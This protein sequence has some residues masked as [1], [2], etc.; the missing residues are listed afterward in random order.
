MARHAS[1]AAR[2]SSPA[3]AAPSAIATGVAVVLLALLLLALLPALAPPPNAS[4]AVRG[5]GGG[6]PPHDASQLAASCDCATCQAL[7]ARYRIPA[8]AACAPSTCTLCHSLLQHEV[9][10]LAQGAP[11]AAEPLPLPQ[12]PA[13]PLPPPP[14]QQQQQQ[15]QPPAPL[16]SHLPASAFPP[17]D[18]LHLQPHA[19]RFLGPEAIFDKGPLRSASTPRITLENGE[20]V[21]MHPLGYVDSDT[22]RAIEWRV[23]EGAIISYVWDNEKS[24]FE[25]VAKATRACASAPAGSA[26]PLFLD[27]GAN[28]GLFGLMAAARGCA[29]EF[30]DPQR[31]CGDILQK[32]VA[33]LPPEARARPVKVVPRPVGRPGTTLRTVY[34]MICAG[35]FSLGD[36]GMQPW[37]GG[38]GEWGEEYTPFEGFDAAKVPTDERVVEAVALDEVI[39]GRRVAMLKVDVEGYESGVIASGAASFAAALVDVLVVEVNPQTWASSKWDVAAMAEPLVGLVR[40]HGYRV[41]IMRGREQ[42]GDPGDAFHKPGGTRGESSWEAF[43]DYLVLAGGQMDVIFLA[44]HLFE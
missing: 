34:G 1:A 28:H 6:A 29:V 7:L 22:G 35:R 39:G 17:V 24:H 41:K 37:K 4:H 8:P 18:W 26:P 27:V 31:K 44:E 43:R 38:A 36:G 20:R 25:A 16:P 11:P 32:S 14:Q 21:F 19:E 33:L 30:Y 2:Q 23:A 3:S 40:D 15:P 10:A 13:P 9:Q 12:P 5:G 42:L